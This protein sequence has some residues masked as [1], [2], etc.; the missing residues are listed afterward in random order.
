MLDI[1]TARQLL[2]MGYTPDEISALDNKES[3]PDPTPDPVPEPAPDPVPDPTPAPN[4]SPA[5][6][7]T[8]VLQMV[9]QLTGSVDKL[10][11]QIQAL[12]IRDIV[13]PDRPKQ[14]TAEEILS[15]MLQ[16]YKDLKGKEDNK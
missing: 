11:K 16:P 9:Q 12:A 10:Q 1:L 2:Q 5:P 4:P 6:D 3:L 14:A 7:Q 13:T 15:Q 8:Q